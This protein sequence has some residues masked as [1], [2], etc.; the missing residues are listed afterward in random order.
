[1]H[2]NNPGH[3]PRPTESIGVSDENRGMLLKKTEFEQK[4]EA[5]HNRVRNIELHPQA[6]N[7]NLIIRAF[8]YLLDATRRKRHHR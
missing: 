3:E 7:D 5:E 2:I 6:M 8:P 1:M 4:L